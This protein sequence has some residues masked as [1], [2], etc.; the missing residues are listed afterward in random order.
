MV[1]VGALCL[2]C[3]K[4]LA[5][6]ELLQTAQ[7]DTKSAMQALLYVLLV[8]AIMAATRIWHSCRTNL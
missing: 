6:L 3:R 7:G 1:T 2:L 8:S 4:Q 5:P